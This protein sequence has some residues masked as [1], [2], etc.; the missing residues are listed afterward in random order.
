MGKLKGYITSEKPIIAFHELLEKSYPLKATPLKYEYLDVLDENAD[1]RD[2]IVEVV[3]RL[4]HEF[5]IGE[6]RSHLVVVGDAKT[7]QHLQN[8]KIDY[9]EKLSWLLPFPG[10]FHIL[11]NYQPVL[12]K[13]Y[14]DAALRQIA[15]M[16]GFKGETLTSLQKC[17]HF[18]NTHYFIM[19]VWEAL[20]LEMFEVFLKEKE[21]SDNKL[22]ELVSL[23]D[24]A[25]LPSILE[26]CKEPLKKLQALFNNHIG[27][28]QGPN[29]KF[30]LQFVQNDCFSYISLFCAI[31]S[32]NWNLRL[33][34]IKNMAPIFSAFD[35]PTYRKV[36]PQHLADCLLL[37]PDILQCFEQG[38]FSASIT[39]RPWHMVALDELHE[40]LINKDC[41]SAV[42]HPTKEFLSSQS[43]YFPFRSS[44]LRNIKE[45]LQ[46]NREGDYSSSEIATKNRNLK[47]AENAEAMKKCI[48][49]NEVLPKNNDLD[50][51]LRNPFTTKTASP[52]QQE[53][54]LTFR[55]IGQSDFDTFVQY[56]YLGDTSVNPIARQHKLKTFA[57]PKVTKRTVNN[58]QKEKSL[59][60]KCLRSRLLWAQSHS[61]DNENYEQQYLELPR[62]IA[63]EN[64]IP[65][66]GQKSNATSFYFKR[67][68]NSTFSTSFPSHWLPDIVLL[69]GMFMINTTP[70]RIHAKMSDYIRHLLSRYVGCYLN[71][72]VAEVH[73]IF[74]DAGRFSV[75][76]KRIE[77]TRRDDS[78]STI[79]LN[80][81]HVSF[82]DD[83]KIPPKWREILECRKCKRKLVVYMGES[84]LQQVHE[85]LRGDQKFYVAGTGEEEDKD[86]VWYTTS[87]GIEHP[88]P[89]Y[90]CVAEEGDTRVW[91]H[92]DRTPGRKKL[93]YSP[94]TDVYH[95]GL[96]NVDLTSQ[97]I[98]IQLSPMGKSLKLLHLNKLIEAI[99]TDPDLS[100]V[101]LDH[102]A[103]VLQVVYIATGC[104]FTSFFVGIGKTAFLKYLYQYA[105]FI[106]GQTHVDIMGSLAHNNPGSNGFLAFLRLIGVAYFQKNRGA[107]EDD[108]PI[109]LFNSV[110]EPSIQ[111]KH[112]KWYNEI[113]SKVWPRISFEDSLPPSH[114]ALQL[115]WLR[116]TWVVDYWSQA[117]RT[118]MI[119][120]PLDAFGWNTQGTKLSVEWDSPDNIE[121]VKNRVAFL[122]HGCKCRTG[123]TTLRC[124]CLKVGR[125]CGPGCACL[126]CQNRLK[127]REGIL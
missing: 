86:I 41:K 92:I 108:N 11:M 36:V 19:E 48:S 2:T 16:C 71:M 88:D 116:T 93:I 13:V 56:K 21:G 47:A 62:A 38:G 63:D 28:K 4:Y 20:Y 117:T 126:Q 1:S 35:R 76:P 22:I 17:S 14:F 32:G 12:M 6:S 45:K 29:W 44:V 15:S 54:L 121:R 43:L 52:A 102:R 112:Q 101:P 77:Q 97:D 100:S 65:N 9:G 8:I 18:K 99:N 10:D 89:A 68:G 5:K 27:S 118:T 53:D 83:M 74:D 39:G 124:K 98:I 55:D 94:D 50:V 30:W 105:Q 7:Y 109:S 127:D 103:K 37:P 84:L 111:E 73:I 106:T 79:N 119:L 78:A 72:G 64:G 25:K 31:R 60:T 34:G 85:F 80:H 91:L 104:D 107:F 26:Q 51:S 58:L 42:I 59:V 113:R 67:Y 120:L 122:L 87:D 114:D 24:H 82:S 96:Y 49:A 70:L 33:A 46:I 75:N 66:K 95:I 90:K 57:N 123:C 40:M 110:I 69:E 61:E 3:S 23:F 115:H 125:Q 81:E